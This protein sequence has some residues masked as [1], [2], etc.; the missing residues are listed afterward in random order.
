MSNI[1]EVT[2]VNL[3][4]KRYKEPAEVIIIYEIALALKNYGLD[5]VQDLVEEGL[6]PPKNHIRR[7]Y[8]D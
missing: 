2:I 5:S 3:K 6:L 1:K 8:N 4:S 7:C